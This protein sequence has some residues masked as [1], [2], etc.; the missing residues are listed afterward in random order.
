MKWMTCFFL[1]A[2]C[3]TGV[4]TQEVLKMISVDDQ[5]IVLGKLNGKK[6][7]FLVDS[8]ADISLIDASQKKKYGIRTTDLDLTNREIYDLSSKHKKVV[9]VAKEVQV[10][11]C[12]ELVKGRFL[13]LDIETLVDAIRRSNG[14]KIAG[15]IGSD[16]MKKY[17]FLIDYGEKEV[18]FS[19]R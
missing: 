11:L 12:D 14:I 16:V 9:P 18:R 3:F 10:R 19:M 2:T 8:G 1:F 13:V 5:P 7:Y 4:F 15:I 6:A 17:A